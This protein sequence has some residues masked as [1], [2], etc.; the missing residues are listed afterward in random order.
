[1]VM[2]RLCPPSAGHGNRPLGGIVL[3][4]ATP[5]ARASDPDTSHAAADAVRECA[6]T[7][8]ARIEAVLRHHGPMGKDAI[9]ALLGMTGVAV[10]RR[11]PELARLGLVRP[12]GERA[13]SAAGCAERVWEAV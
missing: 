2:Q 3:R 10:A 6:A 9:A 4:D 12:T 13:K 7:H 8:R 11:L 5:R 1:M